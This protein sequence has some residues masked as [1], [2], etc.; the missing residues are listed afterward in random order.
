[1]EITELQNIRKLY[2]DGASS[3]TIGKIHG[4]PASTI[5]S[6]LRRSGVV[7]R[8]PVQIELSNNLNFLSYF[9][10]V[11]LGDGHLVK[12]VKKH[13]IAIA[14][15]DYGHLENIQKFLNHGKILTTSK[16]GYSLT[17]CSREYTKWLLDLG[18]LRGDKS[19][20]I[21]FPSHDSNLNLSLV[22]LG[23]MDTD[24]CWVQPIRGKVRGNYC[25]TS[26]TNMVDK[27]SNYL[28]EIKVLHR[29]ALR[30]KYKEHHTQLYCVSFLS[31]TIGDFVNHIYKDAEGLPFLTRKF[32]K[33]ESLIDP[34]L[35]IKLKPSGEV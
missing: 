7:L 16:G 13:Q 35:L 27:L 9:Y 23:L 25:T 4:R 28:S 26:K 10:G 3:V 6:A 20:K 24:G 30:K 34:T 8:E 2:L 15:S 14:S 11:I 18:C 29:I 12:N 1:M 19:S 31:K 5:C 21:T 33:V 32:K 22:L 17:F